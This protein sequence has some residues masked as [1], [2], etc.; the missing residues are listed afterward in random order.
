MLVLLC[1]ASLIYRIVLPTCTAQVVVLQECDISDPT[2]MLSKL[3]M[4]P[5][6]VSFNQAPN[7]FHRDV[8]QL[9]M[10]PEERIAMRA[11]LAY[12]LGKRSRQD[13]VFNSIRGGGPA[14]PPA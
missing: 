5:Y 7:S 8:R 6:L 11:P 12:K 14:R 10:K 2:D 3:N 13:E 4:P 1:H 9:F